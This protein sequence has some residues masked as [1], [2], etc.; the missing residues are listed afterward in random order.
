MLL[1]GHSVARAFLLSDTGK[2][3][4]NVDKLPGELARNLAKYQEDMT[5]EEGA[6]ILAPTNPDELIEAHNTVAW[7]AHSLSQAA[8]TPEDL[9]PSFAEIVGAEF[10]QHNTIGSIFSSKAL[11]NALS[12]QDDSRPLTH[13]DIVQKVEAQ[14]F[15]PYF[16]YFKGA[17]TEAEFDAIHADIERELEDKRIQQASGWT[18]AALGFAAGLADVPTLLP[19]GIAVKGAAKL[20]SAARAAL[21]T[22][23]AGTLASTVGEIPLQASQQLRTK[24]DAALSI[25]SATI[26]SGVLGAS[27][28]GILGGE[29]TKAIDRLDN[30]RAD[31]ATGFKQATTAGAKQLDIYEQTAARGLDGPDR[32][33]SGGAFESLE[34]LGNVPFVGD[35]LRNP[36][37]DSEGSMSGA[38][39]DI[40]ARMTNN[41]SISSQNAAGI[42]S[43][44]SVQA[45]IGRYHGEWAQAVREVNEIWRKNKAAYGNDREA[46]NDKIATSL[47]NG[48]MFEDPVINQAAQV[49]HDRIFEPI[50]ND[51]IKNGMFTEDLQ[52]KNSIGYF[53]IVYDANQVMAQKGDFLSYHA[54]AYQREIEDQARQALIAKGVKA[55]DVE[56]AK[57]AN[58]GVSKKVLKVDENG[59]PVINPKTG[60][61]AIETQ[62]V[63][64]GTVG[65]TRVEAWKAF[66]ADSARITGERD[67]AL[68]SF[69]KDEA[70]P[71]PTIDAEGNTVSDLRPHFEQ[72]DKIKDAR[73]NATV[74]RDEKLQDI[75]A[76]RQ[77]DVDEVQDAWRQKN[78]EGS[79]TRDQR[80]IAT[81][82]RDK[83]ISRI[84]AAAEKEAGRVRRETEKEIRKFDGQLK[85]VRKTVVEEH[86]VRIDASRTERDR[87]IAEAEDEG[88]ANVLAARGVKLEDG[89]ENTLRKYTR[90]GAI[91]AERVAK[92]AEARAQGLY[93]AITGKTRYIFGHELPGSTRG[94]FKA[95]KN[96]AYHTDLMDRRWVVRDPMKLSE[97]YVHAAGTDA[98]LGT[99]FK[100]SVPKIGDDGKKLV[101][102][103]GK[104]V[105]HEVGDVGLSE[106]LKKVTAEYDNLL[107]NVT[108]PKEV[109]AK[110]EKKYHND[111]AKLAE[112][113]NVARREAEK[114][115]Q[116]RRDRDIAN[117]EL[118]RDFA[119]GVQKNPS[120]ASI[121]RA[122]EAVGIFNYVTK[123]GGTVL[124]SL[125]DPI[126]IALSQ[127]FGNAV[128]FG[129][130]P[131]V[132]DM[133]KALLSGDDDLRRLSRLSA[134]NMELEFN[135]RMAAMGDLGNVYSQAD[136]MYKMRRM[137]EE[138][139]KYSG[140]TYWNTFVK[141]VA[142]NTTQARIVQNAMA[143]WAKASKGERAW[144]ASLGIDEGRL[145]QF[146]DHY[147]TQPDNRKLAAGIPVAHWDTW[148]DKKVGEAFRQA[149]YNESFN[150]ITTPTFSDRIAW[151]GSPVGRTVLQFRNFMI[152][153]QMRLIGRNVQLASIDKQYAANVYTGLMGLVF[154]GALIDATKRVVNDQGL[155]GTRGEDGAWEKY[156]QEWHDKPSQQLYNALDRSSVFG[157][158]FEGS[159]ILDKLGL[160]SIQSA[161]RF[162][163]GEDKDELGGTSRTRNV[164]TAGV[165]FGPS[166]GQLDDLQKTLRSVSDG[167]FDPDHQLTR[168]DYRRA[169]RMIPGSSIFW[170]KPVL[171]EG[172]RYVGN[173]M[174]WP[175]N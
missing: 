93:D 105:M 170:L 3:T 85:E 77:K 147:L 40:I 55:S 80:R 113:M 41:P 141:Q 153:Q 82:E 66:Q 136:P 5:P 47:A 15:Q 63:T 34:K 166:L 165:L 149:V 9:D 70:A 89:V 46:F 36:R 79:L 74:V 135:S 60:K 76:Q 91:D 118:L 24:E 4:D 16:D 11:A 101:D 20:G 53:P 172:E 126:N 154:M 106:A 119:R 139:S 87:L 28:H 164:S 30:V 127:G 160:P 73:I 111:P 148:A 92:D 14:N 162:V 26:L 10:R 156:V 64:P 102:E 88:R 33:F 175:R 98:A 1:R 142:Y 134:A 49:M 59:A 95:R 67:K 32:L 7:A 65:E 81:L 174:D 75:A 97:M 120:P 17:R 44:E 173:V 52:P 169:M 124:S 62:V 132:R 125:G 145:A 61:Q 152:A 54:G 161:G 151:A 57:I 31:A 19:G 122:A 12:E 114:N 117:I 21:E 83:Q 27:V 72:R 109:Q 51:L 71:A 35:L 138:F 104:P 110:L 45:I 37:I 13:H 56:D 108:V 129:L 68:E 131:L 86:A 96:P 39:R 69:D 128:K 137:A 103:A 112:N 2:M 155:T 100:K 159:N 167:V 150:T 25:G 163:T 18:G 6:L 133:R 29:A 143:G 146:R 22:A 121:T 116:Y 144:M 42:A 107:S 50:K 115:I 23:L 168:Q 90:N 8:M 158:L 171:N 157:V 48:Q 140:I 43:K 78:I 99:I 84:D 94:Y 38:V 58:L 123:M 130:L